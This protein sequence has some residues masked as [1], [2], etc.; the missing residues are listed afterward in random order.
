MKLPRE[1]NRSK[2]LTDKEI[3]NSPILH[4]GLVNFNVYDLSTQKVN[5]TEQ[6]LDIFF[7]QLKNFDFT[8]VLFKSYY[9]NHR[10]NIL[11]FNPIGGVK[12]IEWIVLQM[13]LTESESHPIE[14]TRVFIYHIKYKFPMTSKLYLY[15]IKRRR[16]KSPEGL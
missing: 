11:R 14:L 3:I 12:S 16:K 2:N 7:N 8:F 9:N 10:N 6:E 1:Q 4:N 5:I 15:L 13:A